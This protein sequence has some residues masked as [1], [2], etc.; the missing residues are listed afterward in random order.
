[1]LPE[2]D[3]AALD[4]PGYNEEAVREDLVTPMLKALGYQPT[5]HLRMVRG[6]PLV[7]PYVMLGTTR[8]KLTLKPDY[9]LYSAETLL[10]VLDA[11]APNE[12]LRSP[13][14]VGQAYSY[15]VHPEVRARAFGLCNGRVLVVWDAV[16]LKPLL[17]I[18]MQ[19]VNTRWNDVRRALDHRFLEKP[20]LREFKP[21]FGVVARQAELDLSDTTLCGFNIDLLARTDNETVSAV[22]QV[23]FEEFEFMATLDFSPVLLSEVIKHAPDEQRLQ[24]KRALSRQPYHIYVGGKLVVDVI[25]RLGSVATGVHEAFVPFEVAAVTRSTYLPTVGR[26]DPIDMPSDVERL[27]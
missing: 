11:K 2:F 9:L 25:G 13:K 24:V 20:F 6:K 21:D 14:H 8:Q 10:A 15:A 18:P 19:E 12:D 5:G 27:R 26:A 23:K 1:M 7:H 4:E 22:C 16:T 17:D 3:F